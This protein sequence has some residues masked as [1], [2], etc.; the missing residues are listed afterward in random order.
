[1]IYKDTGNPAG[2][3]MLRSGPGWGRLSSFSQRM[4]GSEWLEMAAS[5]E[6]LGQEVACESTQKELQS[7]LLHSWKA[8][9]V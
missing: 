1:M 8:C 5:R 2:T 4:G 3:V 6:G 7:C 9:K